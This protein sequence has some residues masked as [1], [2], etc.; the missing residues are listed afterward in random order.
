MVRIDS[1]NGADPE[2]AKDRTEFGALTPIHPT[3]R[4]RLAG[5]ASD[6]T[7]KIIDVVAPIGKGQ[8]GLIVT[9]PRVGSTAV[10]ASIAAAVTANNPECHLMVVL[11]G[12][13]PEEVTDFQRAVKG[14]VIAA[15]FDLAPADHSLVA[16]LALER[17]KRLV[18]L[19]SDVVVLLDSLTSLGRAYNLAAP[20]HGRVL[21]GGVDASAVH[22][23]KQLFGAAR[24]LEDGG[25]LT[26]LATV[27]VETGSA[28]D[29]VFFEELAATA[30]MELR[31]SS[32]R[33]N[34]GLVPAVDPAGS[35]TRHEELLLAPAEAAVVGDIRA[36][37]AAASTQSALERLVAR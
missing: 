4:L 17:A 12:A 32:S 18:E 3:E 34:H 2:S 7:A 37:L 30:N 6:V 33:A 35:G 19:G 25:S 23:P 5:P 11:V 29:E 22:P 36:K 28:V 10:L 13:R 21:S 27:L 24:K 15:T 9:P 14:E 20:A 16:E 1:V 26:I 8:R 31:L